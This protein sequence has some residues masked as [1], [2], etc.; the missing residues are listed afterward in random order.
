[1]EY[2]VI[3][4]DPLIEE[5]FRR[6]LADMDATVEFRADGQIGIGCLGGATV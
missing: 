2:L 5:V 1:M 4:H 6:V 3:T